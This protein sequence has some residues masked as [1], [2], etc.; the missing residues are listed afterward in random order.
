MLAAVDVD[1]RQHVI[2]NQSNALKTKKTKKKRKERKGDA[3]IVA[4]RRSHKKF[5]RRNK[6]T[7]QREQFG[8]MKKYK[9]F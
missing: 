1:L 2:T 5:L 7:N 9:Y 3:V 8:P 4:A 6:N